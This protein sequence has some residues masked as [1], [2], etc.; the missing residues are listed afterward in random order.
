MA[1]PPNSSLAPAGSAFAPA[2]GTMYLSP[3]PPPCRLSGEGCASTTVSDS[4][5]TFRYVQLPSSFQTKNSQ[6]MCA[7]AYTYPGTTAGNVGHVFTALC[8]AL[9]TVQ[10]QLAAHLF[11]P[12]PQAVPQRPY[13]GSTHSAAGQCSRDVTV[14]NCVGCTLSCPTCSSGAVC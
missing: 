6:P 12:V 14:W 9:L 5:I 1:F 10:G 4:Q 13:W 7:L 8:K 11:N 3:P 2:N